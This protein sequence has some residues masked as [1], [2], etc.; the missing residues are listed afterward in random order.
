[1]TLSTSPHHRP[2]R[3]L[4]LG[5]SYTIGEAVRPADR[6]IYQLIRKAKHELN[7]SFAR[8]QIIAQ[9]GW[10]TDEL[11]EQIQI[12]ELKSEY[13][14]VTLLIGVNNQYRGRSLTNY[15]REFLR[16]LTFGLEKSASPSGM[17]VLS[18]PDWGC[19]PF[20]SQDKKRRPPSRISKEIDAF[21][22]INA[23]LADSVGASYI[24][25]T[26]SSRKALSDSSLTAK[27]G[28][29]PS[30]RMYSLWADLLL[31]KWKPK[32]KKYA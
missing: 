24:N 19:T 8:P 9:T 20:V 23:E 30:A 31:K 12:T 11:W 4:C 14:F 32:L 5:D 15:R 25:I 6:F 2:V 1:M 28:L 10:T 18:I 7:I 21:N 26:P 16:L 29:H 22:L 27:D 3:I 17:S 13:D